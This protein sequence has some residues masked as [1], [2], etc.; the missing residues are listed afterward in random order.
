MVRTLASHAS[1]AGSTPTR[2]TVVKYKDYSHERK[3]NLIKSVN[4]RRRTTKK[5]AVEYKG[6]Q[7][8]VCGYNKCIQ[9][10]QFH[11]LDPKEKD[12][13]ISSVGT[14]AWHRVAAELDKCV[15]L[16]CRCHTEVHAGVLA[17]ERNFTGI[18]PAETRITCQ[19]PSIL[20][21]FEGD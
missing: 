17:L 19:T 3:R 13:T 8:A 4:K 18:L 11:H 21:F 6:G 16:C 2:S 5:K 10:L 14:W 9:A 20:S 7:C 1:N 15:L 12:V